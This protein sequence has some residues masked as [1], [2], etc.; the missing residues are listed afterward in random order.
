[1]NVLCWTLCAVA[2]GIT[3]AV[4]LSVE[5][6]VANLWAMGFCAAGTTLCVQLTRAIERERERC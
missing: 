6:T 1:M 4:V 3:G 5:P 2:A